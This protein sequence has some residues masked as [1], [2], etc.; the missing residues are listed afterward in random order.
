[1][2]GEPRKVGTI[3]LEVYNQGEYWWDLLGKRHEIVQM[4]T[5]Y[6]RN[7][8]NFLRRYERAHGE[9]LDLAEMINEDPSGPSWTEFRKT[10]W[11]EITPLFIALKTP[12]ANRVRDF[13]D[14]VW[15][16]LSYEI[17]SRL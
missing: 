1:M 13:I 2:T 7:V 11:Q 3:N 15:D 17:G 14:C 8:I 5:R 6:R 12:P 9:K 16:W 4:N 10:G